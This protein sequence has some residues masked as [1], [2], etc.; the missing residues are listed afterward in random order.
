MRQVASHSYTYS[1]KTTTEEPRINSGIVRSSPSWSV[2]LCIVT[3]INR[4][5]PCK[6]EAIMHKNLLRKNQP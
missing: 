4:K 5:S 3:V 2:A 1:R 6:S